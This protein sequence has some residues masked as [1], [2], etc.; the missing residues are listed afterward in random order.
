MKMSRLKRQLKKIGQAT[1]DVLNEVDT[2]CAT[3]KWL[4]PPISVARARPTPSPERFRG[5]HRAPTPQR[6]RAFNPLALASG[7]GCHLFGSPFCF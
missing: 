5:L 1:T 2:F 4:P 3:G 6:V 7:E